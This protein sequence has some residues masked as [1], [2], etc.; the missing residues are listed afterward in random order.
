MER[1][2]YKKFVAEVKGQLVYHVAQKIALTQKRVE[3]KASSRGT[4]PETDRQTFF[5]SID[6]D[7]RELKNDIRYLHLVYGYVRSQPYKKIEQRSKKYVETSEIT[8]WIETISTNLQ[9]GLEISK[10]DIATWLDGGPSL[11]AKPKTQTEIA[12]VAA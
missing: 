3:Y 1:E 8:S 12:E 10:E 6:A 5:H 4:V 7:R 9:A 11:F 2:T